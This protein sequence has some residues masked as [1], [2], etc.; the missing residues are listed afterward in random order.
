MK[1]LV[2]GADHAG[3][4][5]K[6]KIKADLIAK[7]YEVKDVGTFSSESCKYPIIA[8]ELCKVIQGGEA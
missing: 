4:A 2:M 8:H 7:G 5:L 3:Y 6:D 1:K